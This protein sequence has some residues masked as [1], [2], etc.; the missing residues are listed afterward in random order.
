MALSVFA[1]FLPFGETALGSCGFSCS[2][3]VTLSGAECSCCVAIAVKDAIS[4]KFQRVIPPENP[5]EAAFLSPGQQI[6]LFERD[7][8]S[9]A[10]PDAL[11]EPIARCDA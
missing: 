3:N 7:G 1:R 8:F 5:R 4:L 6:T 9:T 11:Q 10:V 2:Q